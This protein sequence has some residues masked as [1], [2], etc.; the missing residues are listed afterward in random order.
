MLFYHA[1]DIIIIFLFVGMAL[2]LLINIADLFS[3]FETRNMLEAVFLIIAAAALWYAR[4]KIRRMGLD[5]I[6]K[7]NLCACEGTYIRLQEETRTRS[8]ST[9]YDYLCHCRDAGW[10]RAEDR[11]QPVRCGKD[12][13]GRTGHGH[14]SE[15]SHG[16][17]EDGHY[18]TREVRDVQIGYDG[19]ENISCR[20]T[21]EDREKEVP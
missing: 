17:A 4:K 5:D 14:P 15:R 1:A 21:P 6:E 10:G 8:G 18:G 9:R 7:K 19:F 13:K 2:L 16:S 12:G 20:V 11:N 3:G